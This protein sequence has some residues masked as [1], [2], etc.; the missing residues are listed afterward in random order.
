M[1]VLEPEAHLAEGQAV[2]VTEIQISLAS[3]TGELPGFGLWRDRE[4]IKDSGEE[5]LRL[6]RS[7]EQ[8]SE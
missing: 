1:V 6:R 5:S 3:T 8:R 2:E 4:D 7:M